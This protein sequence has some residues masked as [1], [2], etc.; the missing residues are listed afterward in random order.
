MPEQS[1][2]FARRFLVYRFAHSAPT[3]YTQS[4]IPDSEADRLSLRR[5]EEK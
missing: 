4:F 5:M 1:G 3:V 2:D